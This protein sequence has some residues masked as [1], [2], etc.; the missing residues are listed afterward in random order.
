MENRSRGIERLVL[1]TL[2]QRRNLEPCSST[3]K[4]G[5]AIDLAA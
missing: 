3:C 2:D 1:L 5:E 4:V